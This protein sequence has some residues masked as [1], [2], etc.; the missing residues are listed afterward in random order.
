MKNLLNKN[1]FIQIEKGKTRKY[2]LYA[3]GEIII[4]I[5]GIFLAI[6]FNQYVEN[7]SNKK[8]QCEYLNDLYFV[9]ERDTDDLENNILGYKDENKKILLLLKG[10]SDKTISQSWSL[11]LE[12]IEDKTIILSDSSPL[13]IYTPLQNIEFGQR[14]KSKIEE[15][16]YS[17]ITLIENKE[18]RNRIFLYQDQIINFLQIQ[19][20]AAD[21]TESDLNQYYIGNNLLLFNLGHTF[22]NKYGYKFQNEKEFDL[23][24]VLTDKRYITLVL[25]KFW[26][27]YELSYYSEETMIKELDT[28]KNLLNKE[29]QHCK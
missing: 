5:V 18:L 27:N 25:L 20:K 28:I 24:K 8:V 1:R 19:E 26:D 16:K 7:R 17:N 15:I 2:F 12:S 9:L 29:L 3:I 13:F 6:Q 4:I 23:N 21:Q 22:R 14:S 10:I 11:L